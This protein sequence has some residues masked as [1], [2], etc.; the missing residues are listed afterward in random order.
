MTTQEFLV[1]ITTTD[2]AEPFGGRYAEGRS[3]ADD[4]ARAYGLVTDGDTA[5]AVAVAASDPYASVRLTDTERAVLALLVVRGD[6]GLTTYGDPYERLAAPDIREAV[7]SLERFGY[8][9]D[10]VVGG[11]RVIRK[12][13]LVKVITDLGRARY[14]AGRLGTRGCP[15]CIHVHC[16]CSYSGRCLVAQ[17]PLAPDGLTHV[18]GCHGT[19]D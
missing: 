15:G 5:V 13:T 6:H 3:A 16:V 4:F 19:H 10:A 12:A 8:I 17:D 2:E 7:D 14:D 11:R 1:T 9:A 18:T